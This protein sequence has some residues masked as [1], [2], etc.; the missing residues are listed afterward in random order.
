MQDP[1]FPKFAQND[2]QL[3]ELQNAKTEMQQVKDMFGLDVSAELVPLP[4]AGKFYPK[5][6]PWHKKEAVYV[7]AMT[8][9][10]EDI[11]MNEA[12]AKSGETISRLIHACLVG[13]DKLPYTGEFGM[14]SVLMG[15]QLA[16][17]FFIRILG[18]G[19]EYKTE[20]K[21]PSCSKS[22]THIFDLTERGIKECEHESV[23]EG[24]NKFEFILPNCNKKVYFRLPVIKDEKE[25]ESLRKIAKEQVAKLGRSV[26]NTGIITNSLLM[27][28]QAFEGVNGV[29]VEDRASLAKFVRYIPAKDSSALRK[30]I[31]ECEPG[32]DQ[33]VNFECPFCNHS[34]KVGLPMS[35][36]FF[37]PDFGE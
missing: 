13:Q 30:F 12:Y 35:K 32:I 17:M 37:W 21:C 27:Q 8:A 10:E 25:A 2:P 33:T 22:S 6:H 23:A 29:M 28:I 1:N 26:S 16:L 9:S 24:Q 18:F 36:E 34:E 19:P 20:V 31:R 4:S 11:L 5:G 14:P 3:A 15:D 7:K